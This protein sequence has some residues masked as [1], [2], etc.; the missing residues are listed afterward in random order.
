NNPLR[1]VNCYLVTDAGEN[2]L[3]DTGFSCD[4]GWEALSAALVE[5]GV[6]VDGSLRLFI[7]HAHSDH[8]GLADR[9]AQRGVEVLMHSAEHAFVQELASG[10]WKQVLRTTLDE[11]GFAA[12]DVAALMQSNPVHDGAASCSFPATHLSEGD[13]L[14]LGA[15]RFSV[16]ETPG[17]AAGHLCLYHEEQ[18]LL[19]S[20][21]CILFGISPN[22]AFFSGDGDNLAAYLKSLDR[23]KELPVRTVLTAHREVAGSVAQRAAELSTHHAA[24]LRECLE[25]LASHPWLSC[26]ELAERL[27]WSPKGG[28][29]AF[30][31]GQRMF[32]NGECRA[33]VE[34]LVRQ[35]FVRPFVS[36]GVWHYE[37]TRA[38]QA[39]IAGLSVRRPMRLGRSA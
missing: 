24:R 9:F 14:Q 26:V 20:G 5:L 12:A 11:S 16:L 10:S 18:Q 6:A 17:H 34:H 36:G 15:Q 8:F 30:P 1:S 7:T 27:S 19:F 25:V 28:W 33:H 31:L 3:I 37:L 38:G 4:E 29:A 23:L 35:G 22:I 2:L 32:A 21:D 39:A 13:V